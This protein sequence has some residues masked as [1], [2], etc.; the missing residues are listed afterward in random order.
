MLPMSSAMR[1]SFFRMSAASWVGGRCVRS[2]LARGFLRSSIQ[3]APVSGRA[4]VGAAHAPALR[5]DLT[6]GGGCCHV[7]A[8][9]SITVQLDLS[10]SVAAEARAKGLLDPQNLT[11]L[12]EREVAAEAGRK[13]FFEMVRDLRA[14]PGQPMTMDEIQ[15]EVDAVRA[16]RAARENR[17]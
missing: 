15:A 11:R 12:I 17:R 9:M 8:I 14:L 13:D 1:C 10:E 3:H 5:P 7:I 4:A 16:E 6:R 2:S